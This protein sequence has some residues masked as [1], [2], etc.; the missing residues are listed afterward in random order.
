MRNYPSSLCRPLIVGYRTEQIVVSC[1]PQ[2]TPLSADRASA[3]PYGSALWKDGSRR[4]T[5]LAFP[6]SDTAAGAA[7]ALLGPANV[8]DRGDGTFHQ[9]YPSLTEAC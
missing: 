7:D 9:E 5:Y 6:S 3:I 4:S 1:G 8:D 2:H